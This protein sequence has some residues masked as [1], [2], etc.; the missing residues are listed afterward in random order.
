MQNLVKSVLL[1]F[2]LF[3]FSSSIAQ[4]V[5][6][7]GKVRDESTKEKLFNANI[8]VKG[9]TTGVVTDFDGNFT[10][11]VEEEGDEHQVFYQLLS[12][13]GTVTYTDTDVNGNPIGL[14]FTLTTGNSGGS[15]NLT[16]T[17]RHKLNKT[18]TGVT[19]GDITNAGGS[20]DAEVSFPIQVNVN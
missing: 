8:V 13:L 5:K 10:I 20:T 11:E 3:S 7:S 4:T 14:S 9:T 12:S 2:L 17:L 18:A 1:F 19:A 6:I 16:V 15:G